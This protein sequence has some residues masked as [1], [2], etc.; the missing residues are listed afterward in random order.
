MNT[1]TSVEKQRIEGQMKTAFPFVNEQLDFVIDIESGTCKR[2]YVTLKKE[3]L[4]YRLPIFYI[5]TQADE[6][7]WSALVRDMNTFSKNEGFFIIRFNQSVH[8]IQNASVYVMTKAEMRKIG[9]LTGNRI[10]FDETTDIRKFG[11]QFFEADQV[12]ELYSRIYSSIEQEKEYEKSIVEEEPVIAVP[13]VR[14]P[15]AANE[16]KKEEKEVLVEKAETPINESIKSKQMIE[17]DLAMGAFMK[18]MKMEFK[19]EEQVA[20]EVKPEKTVSP[21]TSKPVQTKSV[22]KQTISKEEDEALDADI[23][24]LIQDFYGIF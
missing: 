23:K 15:V 14:K 12:K 18:D 6:N 22:E 8:S 3:S 7:T 10:G 1:V 2:N 24:A 4:T 9:I 11:I 19:K 5:S 17:D 16:D 13:T 21:A 20:K